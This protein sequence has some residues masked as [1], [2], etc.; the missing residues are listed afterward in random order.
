LGVKQKVTSALRWS[1]LYGGAVLLLGVGDP[2]T[3]DKPLDPAS[4]KKGDL[5]FIMPMNAEMARRMAVSK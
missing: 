3:Y 1:N 5:R 2:K 4:V